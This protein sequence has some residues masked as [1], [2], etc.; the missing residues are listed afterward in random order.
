MTIRLTA[1]AMRAARAILGLTTQQ[2]APKLGVSPTTINLVEKGEAV[3]ASTEAKIIS[4]LN[5]L[6]VE[7]LNGNAPGARVRQPQ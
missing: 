2:I 7:V 1:Q 3:R 5:E 4:G 6:G